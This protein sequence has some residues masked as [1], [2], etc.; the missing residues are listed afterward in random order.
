[1]GDSISANS[2]FKSYIK[3]RKCS[4]TEMVPSLDSGDHPPSLQWKGE[5]TLER[6]K[7]VLRMQSLDRWIE[8]HK[9]TQAGARTKRI[10]CCRSW[11]AR[12]LHG[13]VYTVGLILF[14]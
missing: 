2:L 6:D 7:T 9:V 10:G 4:E 1:M 11:A 8:D 13:S 12:S 14:G 3:A 5:K